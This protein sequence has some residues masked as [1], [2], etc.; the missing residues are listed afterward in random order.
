MGVL[1]Q[2]FYQRGDKGVPSPVDRDAIGPWW[3]HLA[4]QATQLREAGFTAI[5]LP[6]C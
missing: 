5:W 1:L 3:D 2:A 6:R 4:K